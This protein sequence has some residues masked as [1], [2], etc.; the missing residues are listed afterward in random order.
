MGHE[1]LLPLPRL[2]SSGRP[3]DGARPGSPARARR[4]EDG[5]GGSLASTMLIKFMAIAAALRNPAAGLDRAAPSAA[6]EQNPFSPPTN[7]N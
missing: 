1:V 4:P 5:T 2:S 7:I 3:A 6:L